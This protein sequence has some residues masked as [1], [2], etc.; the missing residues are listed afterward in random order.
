M[1]L[2]SS[3]MKRLELQSAS[4]KAEGHNAYLAEAIN[5]VRASGDPG[6]AVQ[7][8][9]ALWNGARANQKDAINDVRR[10]IEGRLREEPGVSAQRVLLE[11]G[12][13]RRLS[14]ARVAG[15]I[16]RGN[17]DNRSS[18]KDRPRGRKRGS[19]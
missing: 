6:A 18:A 9:T 12:W 8:L 11:L 17:R 5:A 19:H 13:L 14:V 16:A 1:T 10:W 15:T 2:R 4:F 3:E 7:L